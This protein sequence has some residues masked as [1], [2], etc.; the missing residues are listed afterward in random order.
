ML[1]LGYLLGFFIECP[2]LCIPTDNT[3]LLVLCPEQKR[4]HI[5][6]QSVI[7]RTTTEVICPTSTEKLNRYTVHDNLGFGQFLMHEK[8]SV[9]S[10]LDKRI[11]AL[12]QVSRI[13]S[14]CTRLSVCTSLVLSRILYMLPLY[15][16][17]SD[18]MLSAI[19]AKQIEAMR[20]VTGQKWEVLGIRMTSTRELL[21]QCG[22]LSV[23]QMTYYYSVSIVHKIMKYKQPEYLH[24]VLSEALQ[25]GVQ[26][27]YPTSQAGGR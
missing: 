18:Y 11:G 9:L 27:C 3:H 24:T 23:K 19:Q 8:E 10:S 4:R 17:C 25:S 7:L 13:A 12:K 16:D 6:T 20:I 2:R 26:H 21:K 15:S 1:C 14:F 22:Y 5:D